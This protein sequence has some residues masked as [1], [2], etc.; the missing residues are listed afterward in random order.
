MSGFA[1]LSI[2]S[3]AMAANYVALQT[4]GHNIANAGVEGYSRQ[5]VETAT[6]AAR[7]T[8]SGN[9][10]TGVDV[11][12]V[13]RA[14]DQFLTREAANAKALAGMDET[15]LESLR[16]LEEVF[17]PGEQG[18]GHAAGQFLNSMVDVASRPS[19]LASRQVALARA[20]E[21]AERF[22]MAGSQLDA[23]QADVDISLQDAVTRANALVKGIGELNAA[24]LAAA[25]GQPPNDLLDARDRQISELSGIVQVKTLQALDGS[26]AV[27]F[28]G[29]VALVQ[30]GKSATLRVVPD[31]GD[32]N[33]LAIEADENGVK[34]EIDPLALGGG[35]VAGLMRFQNEDLLNARLTLGQMAAAMAGVVN[36]Q[37]SLGLD[38]HTPAGRGAALFDIGEPVVQPGPDN[39]RLPDGAYAATVTLEVAE[40]R[41]LKASEYLLS[42]DTDNGGWKV[43]RLSDGTVFTGVVSGSEFDGLRID[44]GAS[45]PALTDRFLLQPVTYAAGKLQRSIEDPRSLAAAALLTAD[46][47]A[48]NQGTGAVTRLRLTSPDIDPALDA[49]VVFTGASSVE[50][51]ERAGGAVLATGTWARGQPV[52]WDGDD[53]RV[54]GFDLWLDGQPQ[55]GD[56]FTL[57]PTSHVERN[58]TNALAFVELRDTRF[59]GQSVGGD[60]EPTGGSTLVEAWTRA[61]ADTGV[62]VQAAGAAS[63]ISKA[64]SQQA[65]GRRASQAG[66]NLDEEA[67]RLIQYQQSYQAAAKVLQVAQAVFDTLMQTAA[68]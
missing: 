46:V 67:A 29:G 60:G 27:Y 35:S 44:L 40:P 39:A 19:D 32:P 34:R 61:L 28:A 11:Q 45:P 63:E 43:E 25:Q 47:G 58:N 41:L 10:G 64:V 54:T 51:R 59:I 57:A 3:R 42:A 5:R 18:I 13:T 37:Q 31:E 62:R 24:I 30:G 49:E 21:V 16:R 26:T 17:R 66:V 38:L 2:G 9:I 1:L 55:V 6:A 65:E 53:K 52:A 68:R 4:T 33:R 36:E 20:G 48:D 56:V 23:L 50:L 22:R 12:T 7:F 8:A 14:H 15:R